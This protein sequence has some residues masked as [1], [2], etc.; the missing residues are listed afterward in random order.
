MAANKGATAG[1]ITPMP[2]E[3]A[4]GMGKAGELIAGGLTEAIN[5]AVGTAKTIGELGKMKQEID[6]MKTKQALDE[7][8][9][10]LAE[11]T[12][13]KTKQEADRLNYENKMLNTMSPET[14]AVFDIA[15]RAINAGA[16]IL[17]VFNILKGSNLFRKLPKSEQGKIIGEVERRL[18]QPSVK[19]DVMKPR[20]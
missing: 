13:N 10:G 11:A 1:S 18:G 7:A 8:Q 4:V 5:G 2:S 19:V 3:Q 9:T 15:E 20:F 12:A 14:R 17:Q 16:N 6:S